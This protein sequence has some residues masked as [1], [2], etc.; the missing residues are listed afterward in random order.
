MRG[1]SLRGASIIFKKNENL[2]IALF[3]QKSREKAPPRQ[4]LKIIPGKGVKVSKEFQPVLIKCTKPLW[5]LRP[6]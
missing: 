3:G 2:S 4:N 6:A 1:L 5:V